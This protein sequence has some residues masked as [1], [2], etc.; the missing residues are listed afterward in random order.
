[1]NSSS[2]SGGTRHTALP[3]TSI[4]LRFDGLVDAGKTRGSP[5]GNDITDISRA[6]HAPVSLSRG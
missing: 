3:T 6:P 1:V 4:S 2:C 5:F